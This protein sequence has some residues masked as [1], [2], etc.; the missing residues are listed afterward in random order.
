MT[1]AEEYILIGD[2]FELSATDKTDNLIEDVPATVSSVESVVCNFFSYVGGKIELTAK[3][4][5]SSGGAT[6]ITYTLY[7]SNGDV[8]KTFIDDEHITIAPRTKYTLKA[9]TTG[10]GSTDIAVSLKA[11]IVP[12]KNTF[13]IKG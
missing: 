10:S 13:L 7:D 6:G 9:T 1:L 12:K 3:K 8:I 2:F 11:R 5:S 4:T